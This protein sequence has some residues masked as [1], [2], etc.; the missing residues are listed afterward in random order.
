MLVIPFL[1][2]LLE[3]LMPV[4][5]KAISAQHPDKSCEDHKDIL[6]DTFHNILHKQ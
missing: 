6:K 3:A 2:E 4:L 1:V 5:L